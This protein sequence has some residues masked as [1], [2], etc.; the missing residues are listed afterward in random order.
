MSAEALQQEMEMRDMKTT[1]KKITTI[2]TLA[3]F[4]E[5]MLWAVT[6]PIATF[7]AV[8]TTGCTPTQVENE[9]NTVLQEAAG[10]I[11]VADPGATW[12]DDFSKKELV[13]AG[14]CWKWFSWM[15][16]MVH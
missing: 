8:T 3:M 7:T 13:G 2:F 12:L 11:A 16:S 1:F 5:V 14:S 4:W 15:A 9:I 10:I 6:V